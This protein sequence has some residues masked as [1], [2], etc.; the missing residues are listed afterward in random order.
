MARLFFVL[1]AL[2]ALAA[3][4]AA[5]PA[6]IETRD[7]VVY[8]CAN[9]VDVCPSEYTCCGPILEGVGGTCRILAPGE[10]NNFRKRSEGVLPDGG[11]WLDMK[12]VTRTSDTKELGDTVIY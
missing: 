5:F 7:D 9:G 6:E 8:H 10:G 12:W 3:Q 2:F 1:S 11:N 4:T